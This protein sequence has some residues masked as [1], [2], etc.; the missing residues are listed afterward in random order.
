[1]NKFKLKSIKNSTRPDKKKMAI[2]IDL[3][4]GKTKTTH[5]GAKGMS[6]FT[7][8]KDVERK[9]LYINRHKK[10]ENWNNPTSA[11]ALSRW[12][13]WNKPTYTESVQNYKK[14]FNL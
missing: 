5:F 12:I 14:K 7:I 11:G 10:N 9:K 6:D 3:N 13:L 1:M 2:F 8:H 4:T